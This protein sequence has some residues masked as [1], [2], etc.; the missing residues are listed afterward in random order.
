MNDDTHHDM[1]T[2]EVTAL[3]EREAF[4]ARRNIAMAL[5]DRLRRENEALRARLFTR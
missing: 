1:R 2:A 3:R 4:H 5:L